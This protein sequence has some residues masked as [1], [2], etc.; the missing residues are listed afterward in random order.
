VYKA[1]TQ[2][3]GRKGNMSLRA[4]IIQ[5]RQDTDGHHPLLKYGIFTDTLDA[6]RERQRERKCH[7]SRKSYVKAGVPHLQCNEK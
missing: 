5:C 2:I 1:L 3:Q 7:K 4:A 6:Q